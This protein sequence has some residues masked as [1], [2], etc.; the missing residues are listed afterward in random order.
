MYITGFENVVYEGDNKYAAV[1]HLVAAQEPATMPLNGENVEGLFPSY[2]GADTEFL[3]GSDCLITGTS[4]V[5]IL[6]DSRV[7]DD[8]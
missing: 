2:N 7:W 4:K 8:V 5:K 3:P 6:N 1:V